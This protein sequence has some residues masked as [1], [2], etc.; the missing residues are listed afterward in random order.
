[1]KKIF[2]ITGLH[3][4]ILTNAA[5]QVHAALTFSYVIN[6]GYLPFTR[7]NQKFQLENQMDRAI[8]FGKLQ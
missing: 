7:E 2:Y 1:M 5:A 8:L 4:T 6:Q 3:F